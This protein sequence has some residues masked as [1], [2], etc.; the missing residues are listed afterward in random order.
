[1]DCLQ[2]KF[3]LKGYYGHDLFSGKRKNNNWRYSSK[4]D[5]AVL[6]CQLLFPY[7]CMYAVILID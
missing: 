4:T 1:M 2:I 5:L 3:L 7:L 6:D